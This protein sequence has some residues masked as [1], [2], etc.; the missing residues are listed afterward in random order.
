MLTLSWK[1]DECKPLVGGGEQAARQHDPAAHRGAAGDAAREHGGG[2]AA[3]PYTRPLSSSTS[4]VLE[5]FTPPRVPLSNRLGEN[6]AL[7]VSHKM[8]LC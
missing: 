7:N 8:C 4:A 6:H 2:Q 3:G 5:Y 1:L